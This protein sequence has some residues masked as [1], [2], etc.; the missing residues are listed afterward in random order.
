M[1]VEL[2]HHPQLFYADQYFE[3]P[4]HVQEVAIPEIRHSDY[5]DCID[6]ITDHAAGDQDVKDQKRVACLAPVLPSYDVL[7]EVGCS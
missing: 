1:A 4:R 2:H 3:G 6:R 7:E 5:H